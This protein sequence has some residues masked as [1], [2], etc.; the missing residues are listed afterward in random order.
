[1]LA[2][3]AIR[4][5][6]ADPARARALAQEVLDGRP[7]P[8]AA[9]MAQRALGLAAVETG[10]LPEAERYLR[11]AA[12]TADRAGLRERA[13]EA[14]MSLALV[15]A[16]RGDT[17]RAVDTV[18]AALA[19]LEGLAAARAR[20][21]RGLILQRAGH[22]DE[23]LAEYGRSLAALRRHGDRLWEARLRCNRGILQAYRGAWASAERDLHRAEAIDLEIG[24]ELA[25][26]GVRHNLGF[27]AALR[28]DVPA[29]LAHYDDAARRYAEL[30][31]YRGALEANRAELM[32]AVGLVDEACAHAEAAVAEA[33]GQHNAA[34]RA[35]ALLVL[36]Q[37]VLAAG[38]GP[39][40]QDAA[41]QARELFAAQGRVA[42]EVRAREALL[43]AEVAGGGGGARL[44]GRARRL[45][46]DLAGAGWASEALDVRLIGARAALALGR[47]DEARADLTAAAPARHRGPVGLRARA[48]HAEALLRLADGDR[49]GATRAVRAGLRLLDR[50]R[51]TLGAV[52]L[53]ITAAAVATGLAGLGLRLALEGGQPRRVLE[54]A[55]ASRAGALRLP[56]VRPPADPHLA[57]DVAALRRVVQEV[58]E[59]ALDGRDTGPTLRRQA[60]L[61]D[62]VRR[63]ALQR[64]GVADPADAATVGWD[65][66][67][68]A[69]GEQAL[70]ELLAVDGSLHAVVVAGGRASLHRLGDVATAGR[71]LEALTFAL[72]RLAH[73]HGSPASLAA[74]HLAAEAGAARL[75]AQLLAALRLRIGDRDLVVCPTAA[76]HAVP[77]SLLPSV[78]QRAVTV[79]PSVAVWHRSPAPAAGRRRGAAPRVVAVAGPNLEHA[80]SEVS[81]VARCH[82]GALTLTGR[83]ATV[84]AVLAA[85][86]GADTAHLACHGR[87]RADNPM[88]SSLELADGP[89][90][91]YDL[92]HLRR[93]PR[94]LLLSA[95]ESGLSGVRPGDEIMG[96]A[97]SLMGFG[98]ATLVASVVP[99]PDD[100]TT[101][102]MVALHRRLVG[103]LRPAAAL[104]GAQQER[105][106]AGQDVA[107]AGFVCLGQ[108]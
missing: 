100:E 83:A 63:R 64:P 104:A 47:V 44:I 107:A 46:R 78:G 2:A 96:L 75:D 22:L 25:A 72:R 45:A 80:E 42:W 48:W 20:M 67:L 66:L 39:M 73:R 105:R 30:G 40:A 93:P 97:A 26:V 17:P 106:A 6:G 57:A 35:E 38:D 61:E 59:A 54:W 11:A 74:A 102:L 27:V 32:L 14:R 4:L 108:P 13:G 68:A 18:T 3:E 12:E 24:Q 94:L 92:E 99:V 10:R 81:A 49:A 8:E 1:V 9:T 34:D 70:V 7:E 28:G 31:A 103:G 33:A 90:T 53:R 21:Q 19:D 23:A 88:F 55:E 41:G 95:C 71:E 98:A 69:L 15:L 91:V 5:A 101:P 84:G 79:I 76:L 51:A 77:W 87:F 60:Q 82:P 37:A 65:G 36:G 43:R 29:A 52:E 16:Y 56:R 62:A 58:R 50:Y 85:L 89:L 86:D